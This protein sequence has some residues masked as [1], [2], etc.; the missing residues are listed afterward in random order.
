MENYGDYIIYV[1]ESGDGNLENPNPSYPLFVLAFCIF[2]KSAYSAS[3]SPSIQ[4]LKFKHFGHDAVVLHEREIRQQAQ[5]FVFLKSV[6][7]RTV[8]MND[9]NSLID[10]SEMW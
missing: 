6:S 3:V 8:F 9:L 1:D 10:S 2:R 5:P 4:N 7:K